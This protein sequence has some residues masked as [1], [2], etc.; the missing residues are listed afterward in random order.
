[1]SDSE[2]NQD[3][4][5][6][7]DWTAALRWGLGSAVANAV[8]ALVL[9]FWQGTSNV[10]IAAITAT[11]VVVGAV[12]GAT[13]AQYISASLPY[14]RLRAGHWLVVAVAAVSV[15]LAGSYLFDA[16][17]ILGAALNYAMAVVWKESRLAT[18]SRDYGP[19]GLSRPKATP[20]TSTSRPECPGCPSLY[21]RPE[22]TELISFDSSCY[23]E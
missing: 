10:N 4:K 8:I 13:I 12:N 5:T 22:S 9:G 18:S 7:F 1:M 11:S 3:E 19:P 17:F 21:G 6:P 2:M 20:T 15:G 16:T 14:A 23:K